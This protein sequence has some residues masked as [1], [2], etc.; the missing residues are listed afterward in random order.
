MVHDGMFHSPPPL[1][2]GVQKEDLGRQIGEIE[3]PFIGGVEAHNAAQHHHDDQSPEGEQVR[4]IAAREPLE[5]EA[6][7]PQS[8]RGDRAT[9][10]LGQNEARQDQEE[11]GRQVASV[12]KAVKA[13]QGEGRLVAEVEN[14]DEQGGGEA[15]GVERAAPRSGGVGRSGGAGGKGRHGE[16]SGRRRSE[17]EH[18]PSD[19]QRP[20]LRRGRWVS[21]TL[22]ETGGW[23]TGAVA[24]TSGQRVSA[25]VA[26]RT[27]AEG[28]GEAAR[29][30][31][32]S[33]WARTSSVVSPSLASTAV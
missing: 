20:R 2:E 12:Q 9:I 5:P 8:A 3:A 27:G 24:P 10:G 15:Q 17:T 14:H 23:R 7:Q 13:T 26:S 11:V 28:V 25:A 4:G 29:G 1:P 33:A 16:T 31:G 22:R 6:P 18:L 19:V 32:G 21:E 30:V